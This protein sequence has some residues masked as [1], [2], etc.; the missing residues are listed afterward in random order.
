[1][2][3]A[4]LVLWVA[5]CVAALFFVLVRGPILMLS[6]MG[7]LTFPLGYVAEIIVSDIAFGLSL[8]T[9]HRG[10]MAPTTAAIVSY[11]QAVVT[12]ILW[13]ALGYWQWFV[14]APW[15]VGKLGIDRFAPDHDSDDDASTSIVAM[16][17][18]FFV[19][20]CLV[21]LAIG[22]FVWWFPPLWA[23]T[24]IGQS[25]V[26]F[27]IAWVAAG[28][29]LASGIVGVI[30]AILQSRPGLMVLGILGSLASG[31]LTFGIWGMWLWG[32]GH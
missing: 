12:W 8:S 30:L 23:P 21:L 29:S 24:I 2:W 16:L 25:R 13:T 31:V 5:A 20:A 14:V 7:M 6:L 9:P 4:L 15:V 10:P 11:G 27:Y 1:M 28:M 26:P 17:A 32:R 3:R 18:T 22:A 19:G